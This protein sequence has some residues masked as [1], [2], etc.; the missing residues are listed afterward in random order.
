LSSRQRLSI[1]KLKGSLISHGYTQII[2]I[3]DF[4]DDFHINSFETTAENKN[5][6]QDFIRAFINEAELAGKVIIK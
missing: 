2:H 3:D 4:D 1:I 6:V 5:E